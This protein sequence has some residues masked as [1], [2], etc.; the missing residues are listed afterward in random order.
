MFYDAKKILN[1]RIS[2]RWPSLIIYTEAMP[3]WRLKMYQKKGTR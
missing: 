1:A 3:V 2:A